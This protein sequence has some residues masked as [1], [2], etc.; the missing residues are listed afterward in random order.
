MNE[1]LTYLTGA[2]ANRALQSTTADVGL[3]GG[4]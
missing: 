1:A 2:R 3:R 4:G